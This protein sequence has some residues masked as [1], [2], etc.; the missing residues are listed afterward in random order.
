VSEF[1]IDVI[2][3]VGELNSLLHY[4][5]RFFDFLRHV[6]L[7]YLSYANNTKPT[8]MNSNLSIKVLN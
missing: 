5:R 3:F 1:F 8:T 4:M 7:N 6:L 2:V